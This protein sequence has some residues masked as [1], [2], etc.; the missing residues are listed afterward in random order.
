MQLLQSHFT[1]IH[2]VVALSRNDIAQTSI[3]PPSHFVVPRDN[4]I[5]AIL[6]V[7]FL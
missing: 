5:S 6:I 7:L 1:H 3:T 2:D 4:D